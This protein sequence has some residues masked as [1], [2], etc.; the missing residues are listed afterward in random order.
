MIDRR[1]MADV[2]R[3]IA[4]LDATI[5]A[6]ERRGAVASADLAQERGECVRYLGGRGTELVSAADRARSGV[7]KAIGR[8]IRA[9]AQVHESLAH[10]LDRHVETG[11]LCT[12]VPDPGA[13][14]TFDL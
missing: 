1:A 13:P 5:A 4:E 3:R 10:H 2:Q 14:I 11:R 7:T 6:C 9:I 12:Y 8:A